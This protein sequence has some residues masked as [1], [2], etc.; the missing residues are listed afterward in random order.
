MK[1]WRILNMYYFWTRI[2]LSTIIQFT[3]Q[4]VFMQSLISEYTINYKK[5]KAWFNIK[6]DIQS[7]SCIYYETYGW[8]RPEYGLIQSVGS[9]GVWARPECGL[10]QSVGSSRV[11]ARPE[12]GL[13]QSVGS[14]CVGACREFVL[15]TLQ[16]Y[17]HW[18]W[19]FVY[20]LFI[21]LIQGEIEESEIECKF[22]RTTVIQF[23]L[24]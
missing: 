16:T 4:A 3:N 14:Y 12:C 13:V 19:N 23:D 11:W 20:L 22:E 24:I 8:A 21:W 10:V 18:S 1:Y 6:K 17:V 15:A 9:S 7:L 5:I 2:L